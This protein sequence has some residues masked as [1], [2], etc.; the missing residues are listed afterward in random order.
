M[1]CFS[2]FD[3]EKFRSWFGLGLHAVLLCVWNVGMVF[4]VF[5]GFSRDLCLDDVYFL[6]GCFAFSVFGCPYG[7]SGSKLSL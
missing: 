2:L 3:G 4:A 7:D 6:Y 1:L 5:R